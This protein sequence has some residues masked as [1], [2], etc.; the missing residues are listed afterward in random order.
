MLNAGHK[1]LL[2]PGHIRY[3]MA[4][5]TRLYYRGRPMNLYLDEHGRRFH[6]KSF[7]LTSSISRIGL[8][9]SVTSRECF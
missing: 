1:I 8:S 4:S 9:I 3:E 2:A 6:V 5:L 7:A